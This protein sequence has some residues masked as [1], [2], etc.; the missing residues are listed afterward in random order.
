MMKIP[1]MAALRPGGEALTIN[2]RNCGV[3]GLRE[4]RR[5]KVALPP[6]RPTNPPPSRPAAVGGPAAPASVM[7]AIRKGLEENGFNPNWDASSF[8]I[9]NTTSLLAK[10][11]DNVFSMPLRPGSTT[12]VRA[13]MV[14]IRN[15]SRECDSQ[16]LDRHDTGPHR[17]SRGATSL[18]QLNLD[19]SARDE[20]HLARARSAT[21]ARAE[22]LQA[23]A[24][25][26]SE[27]RSLWN[28][29]TSFFR[30]L[31]S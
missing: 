27:S 8:R 16:R 18:G 31:F 15:A 22:R 6:P 17:I 23:T 20:A 4:G 11:G 10:V 25:R 5:I 30:S 1:A 24:D 7:Q 13:E 2:A 12:F 14:L 19:A 28:T 29:V 3:V 26:G 9:A 21:D